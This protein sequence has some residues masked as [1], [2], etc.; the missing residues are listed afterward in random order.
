VLGDIMLDRFIW[1]KVGRIS[2][3][4]PVPVVEVDTETSMLGGAANV[5]HNL[6]ALGGS[7]VMCGMIG[8]DEAGDKVVELL[9]DLESFTHGVMR[10]PDRPT[11]VKT[12]IVAQG[13]QVVRVDWELKRPPG[14]EELEM[15][16]TFLLEEIRRCDAVIIS[17]YAKGV[18]TGQ[19]LE[20]LLNM[21]RQGKL[22]V[23]VDPKVDNM[24]LYKG[25]TLVTP[26]HHEACAAAK[27]SLD[28]PDHTATAG[29]RLLRELEAGSILVTQGEKGMTLFAPDGE[30]HIPHRRQACV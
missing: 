13:Q 16:G 22:I 6:V 2:P 21:A 19:L 10:C 29:R 23:N 30:T 8:Q 28:D 17:D 20:P 11:T 1:G 7:A 18:V 3:E 9:D 4:A 12:R 5:L 26:N 27:V 25:A 15:L 14:D 24:P